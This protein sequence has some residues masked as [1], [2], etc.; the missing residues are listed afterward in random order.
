[1]GRC[2]RKY[3]VE[4]QLVGNLRHLLA[5]RVGITPIGVALENIETKAKLHSCCGAS[6][7]QDVGDIDCDGDEYPGLN[8]RGNRGCLSGVLHRVDEVPV[9][10]YDH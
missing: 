7:V 5:R 1:M 9:G 3:P 10:L 4:P 8:L 6:E 2:G